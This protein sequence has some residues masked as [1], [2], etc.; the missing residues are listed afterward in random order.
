MWS[1]IVTGVLYA[2]GIGSFRLVGGMGSA[3]DALREWGRASAA[4]RPTPS[5]S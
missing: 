5:S 4:S 1:W 3:M 2:V